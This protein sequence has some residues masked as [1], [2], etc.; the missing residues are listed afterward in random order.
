MW[1]TSSR[2]EYI[3]CH[4]FCIICKLAI[5]CIMYSRCIPGI[6][7]EYKWN[8]SGIHHF[9]VRVV[10]HH[11]QPESMKK[12][13]KKVRQLAKCFH[14]RSD[15]EQSYSILQVACF[16][17]TL[18]RTY[19]QARPVHAAGVTGDR[20]LLYTGRGSAQLICSSSARER[21]LKLDPKP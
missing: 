12:V 15:S 4:C 18:T 20:P 3:F 6:H 13:Q 21:N 10:T 17:K 11:A 5:C 14:S 16:R 8:T 2:S 7:L 19:R 1:N 9:L